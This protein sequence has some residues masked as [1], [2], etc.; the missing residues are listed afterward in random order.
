M[1]RT[2]SALGLT[3]ACLAALLASAACGSPSDPV[4]TGEIC[5]PATPTCP[6]RTRLQRSPDGRNLLDI[7]IENRGPEATVTL[8]VS[9]EGTGDVA[10]VDAR[11]AGGDTGPPR[12]AELFPVTYRLSP[13][14]RIEDRFR[15]S[16]IFSLPKLFVRLGCE[17][18][19][20]CTES[21]DVRA[22]Y[23]FMS[24]IS[25][26][27][28]DGDCSG[29][30]FC[31]EASGACVQ[32][33]SDD[34]CAL[35]QSCEESSGRCRPPD[36]GG[37][38]Q[39]GGSHPLPWELALPLFLIFG[40]RSAPRSATS[41]LCAAC[42]LAVLLSVLPARAR[43]APPGSTVSI[44]TG[45]RWVAGAL[46]ENVRRGLGLELHETL[47][48]NYG[49]IS[50]WITANYFVT[51]QPPPPLSNELQ[52]FGF[53]V[54]PR[55]FYGIGPI[56]L[57]AGAGYQRIGFAPNALVRRTGTDS[58]FNAVGGSL[59]AGYR[60]SQFVV[61]V[62]GGLYPILELDGS[63]VSATVSFGVSTR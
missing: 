62:D 12:Q 42:I 15:S 63:V 46:G 19:P 52:I 11:D 28:S 60:W 39:T 47:R 40:L 21:C 27:E 31:D 30:K 36:Q 4:S 57:M 29:D 33:L 23:V 2:S 8:D 53:G 43:A 37:C 50:A 9:F 59:G 26:C 13:D 3:A 35:D 5:A 14:A 34:D 49:G 1:R 22:E 7:A 6:A 24:E 61:R 51:D 56:E 17:S 45:P 20:D 18:C 16:E 32:C 41:A 48:W 38:H 25:E 55:A 44:G 10:F 54:G 58:N